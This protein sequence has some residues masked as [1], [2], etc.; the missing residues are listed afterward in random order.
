M[1]YVEHSHRQHVVSQCHS[2]HRDAEEHPLLHLQ[3]FI[4]YE[5]KK[6]YVVF[7]LKGNRALRSELLENALSCRVTCRMLLEERSYRF[8][9]GREVKKPLKT[10]CVVNETGKKSSVFTVQL[11]LA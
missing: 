2:L 7:I 5:M 10:P 9:A 1:K 8:N 3:I 4:E 6:I 11:R